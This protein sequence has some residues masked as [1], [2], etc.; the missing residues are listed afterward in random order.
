MKKYKNKYEEIY[1]QIHMKK[2]EE[3]EFIR[4]LYLWHFPTLGSAN[5]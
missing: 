5:I 4:D 1:K 2:L 3:Y